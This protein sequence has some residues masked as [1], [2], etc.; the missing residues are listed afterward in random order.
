MKLGNYELKESTYYV[1]KNGNV[2]R[3]VA[4]GLI[5]NPMRTTRNAGKYKI[6]AEH[7]NCALPY[8]NYYVLDSEND[9]IYELK[10]IT[11]S[12]I[13]ELVSLLKEK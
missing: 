5:K 13:D 12:I 3:N 6:H 11:I 4:S 9:K 2:Y 7:F 10:D 8:T 1:M